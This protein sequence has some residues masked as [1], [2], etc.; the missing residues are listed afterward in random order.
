MKREWMRGIFNLGE[1]KAF[2]Y[3]YMC[4]RYWKLKTGLRAS[5]C[6]NIGKEWNAN[7]W[8][9]TCDLVVLGSL[10][11]LCL[12]L[13]IEPREKE[14]WAWRAQEQVR[15][16]SSQTCLFGSFLYLCILKFNSMDF[17]KLKEKSHQNEVVMRSFGRI[18]LGGVNN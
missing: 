5:F 2:E 16:C 6:R 7:A 3:E 18:Y 14:I 4:N 8:E 1:T 11:E 9:Q 10:K 12:V 13:T 15:K 17:N